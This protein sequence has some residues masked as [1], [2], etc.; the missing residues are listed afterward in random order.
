MPGRLLLAS[1]VTTAVLACAAAA[2]LGA[3]ALTGAYAGKA[4]KGTTLPDNKGTKLAFTVARLASCQVSA[5]SFKKSLCLSWTPTITVPARCETWNDADPA[6]KISNERRPIPYS[7]VVSATGRVDLTI[8]A[9]RTPSAI[10]GGSSFTEVTHV[11]AAIKAG[12]A[13]GSVTYSYTG[14]SGIID[15]DCSG[16]LEFSAKHK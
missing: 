2:A 4:T 15:R 16:R 12:K 8:K 6:H 13:I 7:A 1:L 9:T 5:E 3:A 10:N 14:R 11:V